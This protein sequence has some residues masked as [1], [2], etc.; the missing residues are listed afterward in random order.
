[1]GCASVLRSQSRGLSEALNH[2]G[3]AGEPWRRVA[4]G[5]GLARGARALCDNGAVWLWRVCV[6]LV[7][8]GTWGTP[9]RCCVVHEGCEAHHAPRIS[10]FPFPV[11]CGTESTWPPSF[12]RVPQGV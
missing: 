8:V 12:D 3:P 10:R 2:R 5:G 11:I 7:C 4:P 1:V 6:R 9:S